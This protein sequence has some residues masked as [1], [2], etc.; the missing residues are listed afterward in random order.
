MCIYIY[1]YMCTQQHKHENMRSC[2]NG[3]TT[4]A[5]TNDTN[6]DNNKNTTQEHTAAGVAGQP[7]LCWL[8]LL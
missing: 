2:N 4:T 1:I 7:R 3:T 6:D 8:S 5:T